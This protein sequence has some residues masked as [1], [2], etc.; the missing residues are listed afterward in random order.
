MNRRRGKSRVRRCQNYSL[1]TTSALVLEKLT[2]AK[3]LKPGERV[4]GIHLK[5]VAKTEWV[6]DGYLTKGLQKFLLFVDPEDDDQMIELIA[7]REN[8]HSKV[9]EDIHTHCSYILTNLYTCT[10]KQAAL[11]KLP[12]NGAGLHLVLPDHRNRSC[13]PAAILRGHAPLLPAEL[14]Y[15]KTI[16][17]Y[18]NIEAYY[19]FRANSIGSLFGGIVNCQL[20]NG[21]DWFD[22]SVCSLQEDRE[23]FQLIDALGKCIRV[24][25]SGK[26]LQHNLR[27]KGIERFRPYIQDQLCLV[28]TFL[29]VKDPEKLEVYLTE[30]TEILNPLTD[31]TCEKTLRMRQLFSKRR[32][33]L[34]SDLPAPSIHSISTMFACFGTKNLTNPHRLVRISGFIRSVMIISMSKVCVC[35]NLV[36]KNELCKC[37]AGN[38][39]R[40]EKRMERQF[41][42]IR[43]MVLVADHSDTCFLRMFNWLRIRELVGAAAYDRLLTGFY[44]NNVS[45]K[46]LSV[47]LTERMRCRLFHIE[48]GLVFGY[49]IA[50]YDCITIPL[51]AV[52]IVEVDRLRVLDNSRVLL[53]LID[54]IVKARVAEATPLQATYSQRAG[55]DLWSQAEPLLPIPRDRLL[56][57]LRLSLDR[58]PRPDTLAEE[59]DPHHLAEQSPPPP[60]DPTAG[61]LE[62]KIK[63]KQEV[64]AEIF[65]AKQT[66]LEDFYAV[67][68][69]ASSSSMSFKGLKTEQL[70]LEPDS[71]EE[72]GKGYSKKEEP[73]T[74]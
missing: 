47:E 33:N 18:E 11:R 74:P 71:D 67:S 63:I 25:A 37:P 39:P 50:D 62:P 7:S 14:Y 54:S 56:A 66:S 3:N 68:R 10:P 2:K 34:A 15:L 6:A 12:I 28:L 23:L 29:A 9:C 52:R 59:P 19:S 35:K 42:K 13:K 72:E 1:E 5:C 17:T 70:R 4:N 55:Q 20:A 49:P 73:P 57:G 53:Q 44:L 45:L 69:K 27:R 8:P 41:P 26:F 31:T 16:N 22:G 21:L 36:S 24:F 40:G 65:K 32:P 43:L 64:K 48:V 58:R 38:D 46:D 51:M 61:M 60:A 30:Y